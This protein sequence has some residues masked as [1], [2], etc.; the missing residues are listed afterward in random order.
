ML[1]AELCGVTI[2][3]V[4]YYHAAGLLPIPPVA[5]GV[6][7]YALE[8]VARLTRIRWLADSGLTLAQIAE[9]LHEDG[10]TKSSEPVGRQVVADLRD[11]LQTLESRLTDLTDQRDR[12]A[13]LLA[14]VAD[15]GSLTPL[16]AVVTAF[17]AELE[18]A[19]TD[20]HTRLAVREERDFVELAYFRGEVPRRPRCCS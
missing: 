5:D 13:A 16:P 7:E 12:L 19:A 4:R 18:N 8:H 10:S 3:T 11:A 1:L 17:Y 20:E 6:R 9:M 2:R 15:G 14:S